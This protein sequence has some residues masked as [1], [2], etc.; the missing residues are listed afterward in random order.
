MK[1]NSA[2]P[3]T[4]FAAILLF[5]NF[6]VAADSS[7]L[8]LTTYNL[9]R[10]HLALAGYDPVSYYQQSGPSKGKRSIDTNYK[11][12]RYRFLN[13]KNRDAFLADPERYVPAYGGWCAW[14]MLEGNQVDVNPETY[15]IYANTLLLFYDGLWGD[16][17]KRWAE[18]CKTVLETNLVKTASRNWTEI[19]SRN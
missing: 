18:K 12:V 13:V 10:D 2:F 6:T 4:L 7:E 14:A 11:G 1:S 19:Q 9:G 5:S 17:R 16:T 15:R 3:V 8:P